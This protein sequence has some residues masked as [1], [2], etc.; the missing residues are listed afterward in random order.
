M[1]VIRAVVDS[2][3][4]MLQFIMTMMIRWIFGARSSEKKKYSTTKASC[5]K[6]YSRSYK[7]RPVQIAMKRIK[8]HVRIAYVLKY[9]SMKTKIFLYLSFIIYHEYS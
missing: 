3:L 6:Y 9:G 5:T 4:K 7:S 2:A 1:H 8:Q